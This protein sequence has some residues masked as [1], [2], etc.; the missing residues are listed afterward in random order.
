MV[1]ESVFVDFV[2]D[3]VFF[4]HEQRP[5]PLGLSLIS[6]LELL[7]A[8]TTDAVD[9]DNQSDCARDDTARYFFIRNYLDKSPLRHGSMWL[10][11][12]SCRTSPG[13]GCLKSEVC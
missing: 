2:D 6:V 9:Q 4:G 10:Q 5:L 11:R 7:F 3:V 1:G 12:R 8:A 13:Y